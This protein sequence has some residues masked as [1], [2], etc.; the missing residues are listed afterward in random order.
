V[1]GI[2]R[3][4]L[5]LTTLALTLGGHV[6]VGLEDNIYFVKGELAKGNAPFVKRI[7]E[8]AKEHNRS[9]ATP[10][11]ARRFLKIKI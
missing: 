9:V 2:G 7:K 6:R 10:N 4:Q 1:A 3:H 8:L 11:E 5:P